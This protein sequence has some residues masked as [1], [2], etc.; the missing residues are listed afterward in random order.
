MIYQVNLTKQIWSFRTERWWMTV[1]WQ[2]Q[3]TANYEPRPSSDGWQ[4]LPRLR[5][6]MISD[7]YSCHEQGRK[8]SE[9]LRLRFVRVVV[10]TRTWLLDSLLN[11]A[12]PQSVKVRLGR[13]KEIANSVTSCD[14]ICWKKRTN[15]LN[16][17]HSFLPQMGGAWRN[18]CASISRGNMAFWKSSFG[19]WAM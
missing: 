11:W 18:S 19:F 13:R 5:D 16:L 2:R 6:L 7:S 12:E 10:L 17:K 1:C 14:L 4:E 15:F 8:S 3:R 9:R